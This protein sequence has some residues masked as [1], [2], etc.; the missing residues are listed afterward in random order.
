MLRPL[1]TRLLAAAT[2]ATGLWA[3]GA[4]PAAAC[5]A[6]F[7]CSPGFSPVCWFRIFYSGGTKVFTV[8]AGGGVRQY[9]LRPGDMWCSSNQGT[10]GFGCARRPIRMNC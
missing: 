3:V 5:T 6:R 8:P 4:S 10:P 7:T 2:L 9:G 1:S